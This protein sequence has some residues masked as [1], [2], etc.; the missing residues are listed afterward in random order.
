MKIRPN[1][2]NPLSIMAGKTAQRL[3]QPAAQKDGEADEVAELQTKHQQLQNQMLL[4]QATGTDSAGA[5]AETR[6]VVEAELEKVTAELRSIKGSSVQAVEHVSVELKVAK[7]R[8]DEYVPEE[9]TEPSGR[10]FL[11]KDVDGNTQI[12]FDDPAQ[13]ENTSI[14]PEDLPDK[15]VERCTVNTDKVDREIEKL[16][17]QKQE[18]E[19]QIDKETDETKVKNLKAKL[20]QI[21]RE[22]NQKDN[23]TY[24]RQHATYTFS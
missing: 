16:K 23:D 3:Y 12:Y 1:Y 14:K 10:Y 19:Q 11:G 7:P 18:L 5:T 24:R 22:L 6:K 21:E 15:N 8:M 9:I 4:L 13:A 20:T 17:G 2:L